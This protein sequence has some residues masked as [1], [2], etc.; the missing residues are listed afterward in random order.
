MPDSE[1]VSRIWLSR[2]VSP[3]SPKRMPLLASSWVFGSLTGCSEVFA[4]MYS[5]AE[6]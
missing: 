6:L 5:T 4:S 3:L 1:S 2:L